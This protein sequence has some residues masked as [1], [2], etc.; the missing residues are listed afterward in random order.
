MGLLSETFGAT[1]SGIEI[2]GGIWYLIGFFILIFF[3]LLLVSQKASAENIAF[4]VLS[5]F[6]L[7]ISNGLFNIPI[8]L[9]TTIIIMIVMFIS[10]Y[11]YKI[12]NKTD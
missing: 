10:F 2:F 11:A 12:F 1:G 9:I 3:I 5:F 6:L 7:I 8:Y 4:F